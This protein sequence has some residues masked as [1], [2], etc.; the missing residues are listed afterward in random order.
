MNNPTG[1][2][3]LDVLIQN[4]EAV[5]SLYKACAL[6]FPDFAEFWQR[7]V[8]EEKAH[9]DILRELAKQLKTQQVFLNERKFNVTGVRTTIN[10]VNKQRQLVEAGSVTLLQVTAIALDIERSIIDREYFEVFETDSLSMKKEFEALKEHT[11]EHAERIAAALN[12]LRNQ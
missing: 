10:H 6:K 2:S 9:A 8:M 3:I 7:L 5:G 4:E 12:Q 11:S 1:I